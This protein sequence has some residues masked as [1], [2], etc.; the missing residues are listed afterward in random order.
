MLS[1][2]SVPVMKQDHLADIIGAASAGDIEAL[3]QVLRQYQ[4]TITRFARKYCAT[5][6]DVEDA[7][8][9]TLWI[10]S[11]KIGTLRVASAFVSWLFRV[12]QHQCYRL[13]RHKKQ[14]DDLNN[15]VDLDFAD[16]SPEY[17]VLLTQD[18]VRALAQLSPSYRQ[19]LIM[20]DIQELTAPEV[21]V[22]LDLTIET[23]K[24]RLHRARSALREALQPWRE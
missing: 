15:I 6:E 24:S 14:E 12:V 3:E 11:Q 7:V 22:Q 8:Q 17:C 1:E 9:E 16:E 10:A 4:P 19:V 21:A 13:L 2:A 18:I 20:R 5:P 23:V